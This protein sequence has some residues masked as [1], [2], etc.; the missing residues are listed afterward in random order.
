MT[1][2]IFWER[3]KR[4]LKA[5]KMSQK[6]FAEHMGISINTLQGWIYHKRIPHIITVYEIAVTLGVTMNYLM[7]GLETDI[8]KAREKE[9]ASRTAAGRIMELSMRITEES[10]NM[11]PIV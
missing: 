4:L 8:T 10:L 1:Y 5:H 7:G 2:D 3:V 9:L 6:Q 11:C